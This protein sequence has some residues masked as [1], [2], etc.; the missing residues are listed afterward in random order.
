MAVGGLETVVQAQTTQLATWDTAPV[1]PLVPGQDFDP[2]FDATLTCSGC[3]RARTTN[4]SPTTYSRSTTNG[5]T[6]GTGALQAT[7][8][9]K[10]A[11]GE[12]TYPINGSPVNLDTHFDYPLVALYSNSPA[13]NGGVVDPRFTAIEAAVD[14]N[15][16]LFTLDF[17]IIY[18]VAQMRSIP[19]Q[20]PEETVDPENNGQF[21]QRFFWIGM[22]GNAN[23]GSYMRPDGST[24]SS[25]FQF[26]GFDANNINPFDEQWDDNLFPVF[27]ASFPLADFT[28]QPNSESTFYEFGFLYNSVFGTLPTSSNTAGVRIYFDN[29]QLREYNPVEPV[30][31]NGNNMADLE[32]FSLFMAQFGSAEPAIGDFDGDGDSDFLDFQEFERNYDLANGGG[33][34]LAN[35]LA[36][37]PEPGT[38]ALIGL[39]L[40][41]ML[42]GYRRRA[43]RPIAILAVLA[44]LVS[45]HESA[46]AQIGVPQL[47]EGF[48][49][50]GR[51]VANPGAAQGAN[52]VVA[53]QSA[54]GVSQGTSALKV[55]QNVVLTG[56]GFSWNVNTNPNYSDG[57][58]AFEMLA[59]AVNIGAEHFNVMADVHFDPA[60]LPAISAASVTLGL[61]FVGQTI[62]TYA[63]ETEPFTNTATIPL[64]AFNLDDVEDQGATSYSAQ[65]GIT[66]TGDVD[67]FSVY[68]DNLRLVQVT[69]PDL[70]T[71]E[72]NRGDGS[73]I[74]KNLTAN[75]ISWDYLEIKS[76]GASLD[77]DGWDGLDDQDVGGAGTWVKA[78]GS[79]AT[80]LVEAS[81]LGSHTLAPSATLPLGMLYNELVNAE[82]VD[83][84]IRRAA[85]PSFRTYDQ[86]VTYTGVAPESNIGDYNDNGIVDAADYTV[87]RNA[88]NT[89]TVLLNRDP[90]NTGNVSINDYNS[91]KAN[92]GNVG[93]AGSLG[94]GA[95]PEPSSL[96]LCFCAVLAAGIGKRVRHD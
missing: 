32:D 10:G 41:G 37:V 9:G 75:P 55:T 72:I 74:L 83:F 7:I 26:V 5:V 78:G 57:D 85:G 39:G 45:S 42:L 35:A 66:A 3:W 86:L 95:V 17:D 82:D 54:K 73:A 29:F 79:S 38:M 92:F 80:A 36:G 13:A 22:Y 20:P 93:G 25:G 28:F 56:D 33:G 90:A 24:D 53:Y 68:V 16:G 4:V 59:N 11:G 58:T 14:G 43:A 94:A 1:T 40:T 44:L 65:I 70:L 63:A 69:A 87:W 2:Q 51:F 76:A 6:Q 23:D 84:E 30:D 89:A 46:Q 27:H 88:L 64:S 67:A 71:L 21:P 96:I 8:V 60:D 48:E 81:L 12:Y 77:A 52:P 19:W 61:D 62:G 47:L 15:Q 34:S 50:P 91:W 18:D 49:T 31:F